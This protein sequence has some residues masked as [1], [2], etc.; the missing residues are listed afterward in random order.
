MIAWPSELPK[1]LL[2]THAFKPHPPVARTESERGAI[3]QRRRFKQV[4]VDV[5]FSMVLDDQQM[6]LFEAIVEYRIAH[7]FSIGLWSALGLNPHEVRIKEIG[8]YKELRRGRWAVSGTFEVRERPILDEGLLQFALDG[9]LDLL[10][11]FDFRKQKN[12][13]YVPLI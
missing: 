8:S 1:P 11:S 2:E 4:P 5:P 13:A 10:F 12:S 7:W 6:A 3:K 9:D